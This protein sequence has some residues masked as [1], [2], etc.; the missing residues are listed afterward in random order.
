M[1]ND[2]AESS[3]THT[4]TTTS[5][6]TFTEPHL[7]DIVNTNM[8]ITSCLPRAQPTSLVPSSYLGTRLQRMRGLTRQGFIGV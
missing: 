4:H 1:A 2:P 6:C 8:R 3:C 7:P 5:I